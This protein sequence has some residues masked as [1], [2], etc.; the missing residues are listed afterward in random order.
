MSMRFV[1]IAEAKPGDRA[2]VVKNLKNLRFDEREKVEGIVDA[3][4]A[5][6]KDP[7]AA[8]LP[9]IMSAKLGD[10]V[11]APA[12]LQKMGDLLSGLDEKP[13]SFPAWQRSNSFKAWMW[14]RYLLAADAVN[15]LAN[16]EL[17]KK[18]LAGLLEQR[19]TKDDLLAFFAWAWGYRGALNEAEYEAS[20][21]TM[22][23]DA[24]VLTAQY[25]SPDKDADTSP[26]AVH[27]RLSNAMWSWVMNI[28]AAAM[29]RDS[30]TYEE[31]KRQMKLITGQETVTAALETALLRTEA[32]NDYPGWGMAIV[33]NAAAI[34]EDEAL[35]QE[36]GKA[37][38][39]IIGGADKAGAKAEYAFAVLDNQ[40]ALH[41][42]MKL[43]VMATATT[44]AP[45]TSGDNNQSL[46]S[47]L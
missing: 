14:G 2:Q 47:K 32:S 21:V 31:I 24:R 29:L 27:E 43:K 17:A 39:A 38:P 9:M 13:E 42:H 7:Y 44:A 5:E 37:L 45:K 36:L 35:F 18:R 3:L 23:E 16:R 26:N 19:L 25:K 6:A 20:K 46:R 8:S 1:G 28:Q 4:A 15:D 22:L 34:M 10:A 41:A 11:R 40:L 30:D 12:T 33:R